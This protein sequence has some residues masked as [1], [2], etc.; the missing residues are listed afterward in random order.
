MIDQNE[1]K[2]HL[3][4]IAKSALSYEPSLILPHEFAEKY[5][6]LSE[7]ESPSR[8][9]AFSYDHTPLTKEIIDCL[10]STSPVNTVAIMKSAQYGVTEGLIINGILYIISEAPAPTMFLS[11]DLGL[12]QGMIEKRLDPAITNTC[13]LY[14][15]PSPR[16]RTRSRMPSSA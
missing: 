16:D 11:G 7:A 2:K 8:A 14:T 13:L 6:I 3:Y 15:S 10:S 12:S 1:I 5:R 4:Y 9:G